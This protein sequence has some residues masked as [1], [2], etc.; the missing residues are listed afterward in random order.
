MVS[1]SAYA[2]AT[3]TPPPGNILISVRCWVDP[4]GQ[5]KIPMTLSGIETA[6][7]KL[8]AQCLNQLRHRVYL[9]VTANIYVGG[10]HI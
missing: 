10:G 6:I 2:P 8:L 9:G 5:W 1:L 7:L 4:W 3:F